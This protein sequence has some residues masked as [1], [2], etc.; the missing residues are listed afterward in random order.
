[1]KDKYYV[2]EQASNQTGYI[3]TVGRMNRGDALSDFKTPEG[4]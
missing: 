1:M 3:V 4:G 2:F